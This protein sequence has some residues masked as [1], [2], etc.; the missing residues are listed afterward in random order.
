[1]DETRTSKALCSR[2][3]RGRAKLAGQQFDIPP[4][5]EDGYQAQRSY[6]IA[7]TPEDEGRFAHRRRL[8]D[9]EV[10]PDLIDELRPGG[11]LV[12]QT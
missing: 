9:G 12:R 6:P 8:D 3:R 11:E 5:A 4:D 7:W 2:R 10:S 1:V